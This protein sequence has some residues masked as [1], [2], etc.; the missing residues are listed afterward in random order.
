MKKRKIIYNNEEE[1]KEAIYYKI[2]GL[3]DTPSRERIFEHEKSHFETAERLNYNPKYGYKE[4][5]FFFI[6]TK[7]PFIRIEKKVAPKDLK[8]IS[9][10]PNE[11]SNLDKFYS[12]A[13]FN[14][15]YHIYYKFSGNKK[16]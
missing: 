16:C 4:K 9:L 12:S 2:S 7:T 13:L 5:N 11:P 8:E 15:F 1:F 6:Q 3:G 14:I 10:A